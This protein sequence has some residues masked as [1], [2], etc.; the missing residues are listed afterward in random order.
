MEWVIKKTVNCN[1][2]PTES[3]QNHSIAD[4][5]I[6]NMFFQKNQGMVLKPINVAFQWCGWYCNITSVSSPSQAK[7]SIFVILGLASPL[8]VV[9]RAHDQCHYVTCPC[10]TYQNHRIEQSFPMVPELASSEQHGVSYQ[11][12]S[13]LQLQSHRMWSPK[14]DS[15]A[16]STITNMFLSSISGTKITALSRAF[17]WCLN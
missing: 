12:N 14:N 6:T 11:E 2:S 9:T 4:G 8:G 5:T 16:D 7:K 15:T 10:I 1:F 17:Q 3:P 13:E